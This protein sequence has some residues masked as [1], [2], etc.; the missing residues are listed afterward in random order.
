MRRRRPVEGLARP[1]LDG[2]FGG[3]SGAERAGD[4]GARGNACEIARRDGRP[5]ARPRSRRPPAH[6]REP[7]RPGVVTIHSAGRAEADAR[8]R[9]GDRLQPARP[10]RARPE[11]ISAPKN[12]KLRASSPPKPSRSRAGPAPAQRPAIW[13]DLRSIPGL[14]RKSAPAST[15]LVDIERLDDGAHADDDVVHLGDD[16][17]D[18][19]ERSRRP[20]GDL[21]RH[22][23]RRP[24]G[25]APTAPQRRPGRWSP[26]G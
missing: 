20:K 22:S 26:P 12:P 1:A 25:R 13:Q 19:V 18:R 8:Q 3:Q 10:P 16:R 24:A 11:R 7:N 6:C 14:T 5:A 2:R 9:L 4:A 17:A 23:G 15:A 21:D